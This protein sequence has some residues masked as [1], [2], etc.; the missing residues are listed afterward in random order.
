MKLRLVFL[1][2]ALVL[3]LAKAK[4]LAENT[5]AEKETTNSPVEKKDVADSSEDT[6]D[7]N[8][9]T[10]EKKDEV[11]AAPSDEASDEDDDEATSEDEASSENEN[12]SE[13]EEE[14]DDTAAESAKKT[15]VPTKIDAEDIADTED[16]Q[17]DDSTD[18]DD[19]K[20]VDSNASKRDWG[21]GYGGHEGGHHGGDEGGHEGEHGH[22]EHDHH[23]HDHHHHDHGYEFYEEWGE[24]GGHEGEHHGHH[25][26]GHHGEHGHHHGHHGHERDTVPGEPATAKSTKE[27]SSKKWWL[28]GDHWGG[29][30]H[31]HWGHPHA[32]HE[33]GGWQWGHTGLHGHGGGG[34]YKSSI[35]DC[36]KSADPAVTKRCG[37]HLGTNH[38][39]GYHFTDHGS[40]HVDHD[41][42]IQG[43]WTFGYDHFGDDWSDWDHNHHNFEH[44]SHMHHLPHDDH[45]HCG[46]GRAC[47]PL[48][49][50][51]FSQFYPSLHLEAPAGFFGGMGGFSGYGAGAYGGY[52]V[53]AFGGCGGYGCGGG[54]GGEFALGGPLNNFNVFGY[55]GWP[56]R[57]FDNYRVCHKCHDLPT[58]GSRCLCKSVRHHPLY[59]PVVHRPAHVYIDCDS[60]LHQF[61]QNRCFARADIPVPESEINE[62]GS[63]KQG[64]VY[65]YVGYG[66]WSAYPW[67]GDWWG[68]H[69]HHAWG[70]GHGHGGHHGCAGCGGHHG[71]GHHGFAGHG[72]V[73]H[74][75][76]NVVGHGCGHGCGGHHMGR[77]IG[78]SFGHLQA[79][80]CKDQ[81][82]KSAKGKQDATAKRFC[83]PI[84]YHGGYGFPYFH[85]YPGVGTGLWGWGWPW[86]K[87]KVPGSKTKDKK[88]ESKESKESKKS[89]IPT[90][91]NK[92]TKKQT[93]HVGYG[94][95]SGDN[96]RL[97]YGAGG[98]GGVAG[99]TGAAHD[100]TIEHDGQFAR[101]RIPSPMPENTKD[102]TGT[103]RDMAFSQQQ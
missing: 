31:S 1:V 71:G 56:L 62:G 14:S 41:H 87:N 70:E 26:G 61:P 49:A 59:L 54:Y 85:G 101:S 64:V 99:F 10:E 18:S 20:P 83:V 81:V 15:E 25:E 100:A 102:V 29:W 53:G 47:I 51:R 13:V 28:V 16:N 69:G 82:E 46:H 67:W 60:S 63:A 92:K 45:H 96:Y 40:G 93:I 89:M 55:N 19:D 32:M 58:G 11:E 73:G 66:P 65:P 98:M 6:N 80:H 23:G 2:L 12:K 36:C 77:D 4:P 97:G 5:E 103:K 42:H 57:K 78:F 72:G 95:A 50:H 17:E 79:Y 27:D 91:E 39:G 3:C 24:H 44:L 7:D 88:I 34:H 9:E 22:H 43:P 8:D 35:P 68:G 30:G 84:G 52:G 86:I 21:G 37:C 76:G 33:G 94:F 90:E 38:Y 75:V 48:S 74:G